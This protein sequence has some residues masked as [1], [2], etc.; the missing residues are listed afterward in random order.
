MVVLALAGTAIQLV[1][2]GTLLFHLLLILGMVAVLNR[3]LLG[4]INRVLA[5]R[6]RRTSGRLT[7]AGQLKSNVDEKLRAYESALR[8]ARARGYQLADETRKAAAAERDR[9][10]S[11]VRSEVTDWLTREKSALQV[12]QDQ[13]KTSLVEDA[14]KRAAEISVQ[15]LG[16]PLER[17]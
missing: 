13:V 15:I 4:P 2:D 1:P 12:E 8:E 7:E 5:E 10:V 3:T 9:N 14:H 16:R 11:G 6:D 17:S